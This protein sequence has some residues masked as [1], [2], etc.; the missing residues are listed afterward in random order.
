M[1]R[2]KNA[3][4]TE[5]TP[6]IKVNPNYTEINVEKMKEEDSVFRCYKRLIPLRK[7]EKILIDKK[8]EL[9]MLEDS[10]I[11]VYTRKN[12]METLLVVCNFT[13]QEVVCEALKEWSDEEILLRN[14]KDGKIQSVLRPYEAVMM[15]RRE[16]K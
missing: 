1:E 5:G 14:Y 11:F 3:G 9:L 4:F 12:V 13:D 7:A 8:Y 2:R 15:I 10:N 16:G 6:W